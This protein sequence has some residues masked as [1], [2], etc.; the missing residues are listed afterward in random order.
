MEDGFPERSPSAMLE[1]AWKGQLFNTWDSSGLWWR[2]P[3]QAWY[4]RDRQ[5]SAISGFDAY[6][7]RPLTLVRLCY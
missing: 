6:T 5:P 3:E 1:V 4:N 7:S 2:L